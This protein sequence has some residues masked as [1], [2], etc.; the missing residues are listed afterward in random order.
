MAETFLTND[1]NSRS[2]LQ[3]SFGFASIIV[4]LGLYIIRSF[5]LSSQ[6]YQNMS[7]QSHVDR[8]KS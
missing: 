7:L 1:I 5:I 4:N 6:K 8:E 3:M 2:S